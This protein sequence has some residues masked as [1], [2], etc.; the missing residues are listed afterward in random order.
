[1]VQKRPVTRNAPCPI[2]GKPDYCWWK[3]REKEP[4]YY[5]LYCNRTSEAKGTI[6]NGLDGNEY[7]AI[8]E[9]NPGTIYQSVSDRDSIP[10]LMRWKNCLM[11]SWIWHIG[12]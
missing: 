8:Y 6:V 1:M 9:N 3:E 11:K 4:G 7:V 12:H 10:A 5:N 2:C